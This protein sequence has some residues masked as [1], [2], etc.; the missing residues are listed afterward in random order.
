MAGGCLVDHLI[1]ANHMAYKKF[2][3]KH[4][5]TKMKMIDWGKMNNQYKAL[6]FKD[7]KNPRW[8]EKTKMATNAIDDQGQIVGFGTWYKRMYRDYMSEGFYSE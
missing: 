6:A 2:C 5:N 8:K 7:P 3:M 4:L 1:Q